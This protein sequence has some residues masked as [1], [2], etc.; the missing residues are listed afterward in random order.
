MWLMGA[1]E[2][3]MNWFGAGDRWELLCRLAGILFELDPLI[4]R[5]PLRNHRETASSVG[6][7]DEFG[8]DREATGA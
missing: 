5:P 6:R 4:G 7:L 8:A 2:T 1:R 3:A